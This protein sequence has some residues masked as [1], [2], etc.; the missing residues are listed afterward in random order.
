VPVRSPQPWLYVA[1]SA[2]QRKF[3]TDGK[4]YP[5]GIAQP[6]APSAAP[7][8]TLRAPQATTIASFDSSAGWAAVGAIAGAPATA[9]RVSTT[10]AAIVYDSGATGYAS[11]ALTGMT[12]ITTGMYLT[13]A[14]AE[15]VLVTDI[16]IA[17]AA[18]TIASIIYDAGASGACTIQP[19]AS[20]GVGQLE[21]P[22]LANYLQRF[23]PL[24]GMDQPL[25]S[26]IARIRQ[27]DFPVNCLVTLAGAETVRI[28]SVALG[29]DGVQSFRCVTA[30]TRS[31]GDAISG[32][33]G[34]RAAFA[35]TR[36]PGDSAVANVVQQV[37]TPTDTAAVVGG[38]QSAAAVN[39]ARV[40]TQA[41]QADDNIHLAVRVDKLSAV[42]EI[43]L[44]LDV[45]AAAADFVSNYFF[46]AWR[47]N[48][49]ITAIQATNA[50]VVVPV[51]DARTEDVIPNNQVD[52]PI[53][54]PDEPIPL[55]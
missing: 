23:Y 12:N 20:L 27:V 37:L 38:L 2:R 54:L 19:T 43:R 33:A 47:A 1:D 31:A 14:G 26:P 24:P 17:V 51:T 29:P 50:A 49:I 16:L 34:F 46:K 22:A 21:G 36:V 18:T 4:V 35:G 9:N 53:T 44:Y 6:T 40:G 28:T 52:Q 39:L 13:I 48:D 8:V 45:N 15:V 10:I 7:T 55:P 30:G 25:A 5:I 3:A 11:C 42:T 32:L 41:T